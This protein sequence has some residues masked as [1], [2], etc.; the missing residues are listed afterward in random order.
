MS[1]Q[2]RLTIDLDAIATNYRLLK[3][4]VAPAECAAVIKANAYGLGAN[5]IGRRLLA[6]G[7]RTFFFAHLS[8]ALELA[9]EIHQAGGTVFTLNGTGL[10][11]V[12]AFVKAGI[13]P[14]LNTLEETRHWAG[15]AGGAAAGLHLDTG[16]NR[17]GLPAAH[18]AA[19]LEL[20]NGG[21]NLIHLMSHPAC[22]DEPQRAENQAQLSRFVQRA[23]AFGDITKSFA[24]SAGCFLGPEYRFD[25]ARPGLALYGAQP[26]SG[27][28]IGLATPYRFEAPVLQV[29]RFSEG[30]SFGYGG[31]HNAKSGGCS[32][33]IGAGYADGV[34]R[35]LSNRGHIWLGGIKA[36]I[37]GR[38]SMDS[39]A[40]DISAHPD[41]ESL[42][43]E[44]AQIYGPDLTV[45]AQ[46][47]S[48]GLSAYELLTRI[49]GRTQRI[50]AN[51]L[52]SR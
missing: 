14:V 31:T 19:V 51:A 26:V 41:P 1:A 18:D 16:M 13:I 48:A 15:E 24:N 39:L 23:A 43:H 12:D 6:E 10:Y 37:I 44:L 20:K 2:P 50:I 32:A 21:L 46:A 29:R 3:E 4:T 30:E 52:D 40:A 27:R 33:T 34:P 5:A 28:R 17:L 45:D 42:V 8:E 36:P 7:C 47:A 11:P 22:A 25:L 38:I 9:P 49:G 35:C